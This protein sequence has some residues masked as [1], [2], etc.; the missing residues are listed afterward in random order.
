MEY[1]KEQLEVMAL[2]TT[3]REGKLAVERT[4]YEFKM[5]KVWRKNDILHSHQEVVRRGIECIM[6]VLRV[7]PKA[8]CIPTETRNLAVKKLDDFLKALEPGIPSLPE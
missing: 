7:D 2:E 8:N 4:E 3:V 6:G 1:T 5:D